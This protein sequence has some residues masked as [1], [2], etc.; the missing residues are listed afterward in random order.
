[1]LGMARWGFKM[2]IKSGPKVEKSQIIEA[3]A[4]SGAL[5]SSKN[6]QALFKYLLNVNLRGEAGTLTT[7]QIA[8]DVFGR[9]ETFSTKNDSIVRVEMHRLRDAL[10]TFN[11]TSE[12]LKITLPKSSYL[13]QIENIVVKQP[14][15]TPSIKKKGF[16][17]LASLAALGIVGFAFIRA[18]PDV[19]QASDCSVQVPN[20]EISQILDEKS[21]NVAGLSIYID[22]VMRGSASQY[23]NF[24]VVKDVK[25]CDFAGVPG[26]KIQYTLLPEPSNRFSANVTTISV[27]DE[28][29]INSQ[30]I[31]G[32]FDS[33]Q[34]M[35]SNDENSDMYF[36]IAKTINDLLIPGG[37]THLLAAQQDWK[38]A[39][40][41]Q[42]YSCL[43]Q[44]H[45]SFISD[46]EEDYFRGLKCLEKS[47]ENESPLLDNAGGLAASYL[48]QVMGNRI[49]GDSDPFL[50]AKKIM[51]DVGD[52]WP[53][54][55]ETTIA[56]IMY[57]TVRP[58]RNDQELLVTLR[59]SEKAYSSHPIVLL[60]VS[61]HAGF[62]LGDWDYAKNTMQ[63]AK[64]LTSERNN[65][66]YHVDAVFALVEDV[67]PEAWED[68]VKAY[69]EHSKVSNLL[70]N[71]C[72]KKFVKPYWEQQT[73]NNLVKF[74]LNNEEKKKIF[75]ENMRF[76]PGLIAAITAP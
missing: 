48:E 33:A 49:E 58:D 26:Y 47:Y 5:G 27:A 34:E 9:D 3:I 74:D 18:I 64:R 45:E 61:R 28:K 57:D 60:D 24:N 1:M 19:R 36:S 73:A 30:N 38:T 51:E 37:L 67:S 72:A 29:I 16:F 55:P 15:L 43:A 23:S 8:I 71:A 20:L 75:M 13:L 21:L 2:S 56:K 25:A 69:S 31:N 4:G 76:E 17:G 32:V 63:R 70:V 46:S 22:Q 10:E 44:M 54:S 62:M 41:R 66:I 52:Q 50:Q 59:R 14:V 11:Q 7:R 40:A 68:C 35:P 6:R 12:N 39:A 65:A 53:Q 42:D